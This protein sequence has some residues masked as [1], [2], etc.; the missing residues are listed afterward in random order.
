ML[1]IQKIALCLENK[2]SLEGILNL[3]KSAHDQRHYL[4]FT[5]DNGLD[6]LA[7]RDLKAP[8]SALS[9]SVAA[10]HF[11]DDNDCQGMSHLLEHMLFLGSEKFPRPNSI[12]DF[13][14][15]SGGSINAWTGT[16]YANFHFETGSKFLAEGIQRF[17]DMIT[18][19]ILDSGL[20]DKEIQA[21]DA[22]F[23]LKQKDDLRR[24][25][26]VHKETCNP[27]HPFSKFSVGNEQTLRTHSLDSLKEKLRSFHNKHY[28][29]KNCK[30]CVVS[31]LPIEQQKSMIEEC[32]G[33]LNEQAPELRRE[34]PPLYLEEQLGIQIDIKPIQD[35][36]RLIVTFALPDVDPHYRSKPVGL[37]GHILGDE[38]KGSLLQYLKSNN[39]V[40]SLSAG[41]GIHGRNFKDFN[42]NLQ[43]TT[44]G[45]ENTEKIIECIFSYVELMKEGIGQRW[46]YEEKIKYN[47]QAFDFSDASKSIDDACHY[48]EQMFIYPTEHFVAG[49]FLLD[50]PDIDLVKQFLDL[51]VPQNMRVKLIHPG[52]ETNQIAQWYETPY[53]VKTIPSKANDKFLNPK[54]VE[55]LSLPSPNPYLVD[56]TSLQLLDLKYEYPEIIV[57]KPGMHFWFGQDHK[58]CQPKGD[59]F[60]SFDCAAV[61]QGVESSTHKRIWVAMMMEQFN[62]QYYQAGSAGLHYHLYAHQAG[63]SLHTN[64]FSQKQLTLCKDIVLQLSDNES[65]SQYFQ[66]TKNRQ[67]I[68]LQNSLMNKPINRLFTRLSVI[69]QRYSYAPADMLPV[70]QETTLEDIKSVQ[71]KMLNQ[72]FLET[73][74]HGDWSRDD[75][76]ELGVFLSENALSPVAGDKIV[77]D[78]ADLRG[79]KNY[80]HSVESVHDD[81]AVVIYLQSP[82]ASTKDIAM[83]IL[84]EQI[85]SSPFFNQMRTEKQLGYLVGSGYMPFNQ[86]P[87]MAFYI[88]SPVVT[89]E[90]L[91]LEILHF[92]QHH[93]E[94]FSDFSPI[95]HQVK[96]SVIKQL[97]ENDTN[98]SMKSQRYWM[99]IGNEDLEF[100]QRSKLAYTVKNLSIEHMQEF[101]HQILSR[102]K[103]G[104]LVLY[105]DGKQKGKPLENGQIIGNLHT[106]KSQVNYII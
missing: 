11:E 66:Q 57:Q 1:Y 60:I 35:A 34:L 45:L 4:S 54:Q 23:K 93:L 67:S 21:I 102:R 2:I 94:N 28:V 58:F 26:Q 13:F 29:A 80:L 12:N 55:G 40:T 14:A 73:F 70:L 71:E 47:Q 49:D 62:Q 68:A 74:L 9:I 101:C 32:F 44:A 75:A 88:Q 30:V 46:R 99:A 3:L 72:Y 33:D 96:S 48:A 104:E 61:K 64:G 53:K 37:I 6:V 59:C 43:L 50:K 5:L 90:N 65:F 17:A 79:D 85:L 63:F 76:D 16:E 69:M 81:A 42:I 15:R 20:L 24:L 78:V 98:L 56:D 89:A 8:K 39:W 7:V 83:T 41:G 105:S 10:G 52:V 106:F 86:H 92:I 100:K 84:L 36:K 97:V 103:V 95:W 18:S 19:P 87:G 82:T 77:R 91:S 31:D 22:E 51:L 27:A 25:Y 38:G